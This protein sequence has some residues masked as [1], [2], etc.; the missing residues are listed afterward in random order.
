M[1]GMPDTLLRIIAAGR[2]GLPQ[3]DVIQRVRDGGA[4]I[5]A[6]ARTVFRAPRRPA[7][8]E[9]QIGI[10]RG[11]GLGRAFR[12]RAMI[13]SSFSLGQNFGVPISRKHPAFQ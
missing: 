3:T 1:R 10:G 13:G 9:L 11:G 12:Y 6:E 4:A 7:Y 2:K 8:P 5:E